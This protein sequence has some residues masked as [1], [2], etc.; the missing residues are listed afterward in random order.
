METGYSPTFDKYGE[1]RIFPTIPGCQTTI[2][3]IGNKGTALLQ[4]HIFKIPNVEGAGEEGQLGI[5]MS[6]VQPHTIQKEAR[7][8]ESCHTNPAALGFGING[9]KY[10]PDPSK[11][12]YVEIGRAHV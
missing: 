9:G 7:S 12:F 10:F 11:D 4:N 1:G 8:C 3:V 6:P 2:M 5:D